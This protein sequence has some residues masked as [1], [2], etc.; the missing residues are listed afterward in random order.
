M[1]TTQLQEFI[2][3][4]L[5]VER[6]AHSVGVSATAREIAVHHGIDVERAAAAGLIHDITRE[7]SSEQHQKYL[8]I[9][10]LYPEELNL[11]AVWHAWSG[12]VFL[13]KEWGITD[14]GILSAVSN[15]TTG[16][17]DMTT[18]DKLI[19][20]ADLLEHNRRKKFIPQEILEPAVRQNLDEA[21]WIIMEWLY[22]HWIRKRK[23]MSRRSLFMVN[24]L[25]RA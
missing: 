20:V 1:V 7:W 8:D 5:S 22:P 2:E 3:S 16:D 14:E 4:S 6:Y 9:S 19:F 21:I 13:K 23:T 12:A 25:K 11:P 24:Q 10:T 15:H 18:F 17:S